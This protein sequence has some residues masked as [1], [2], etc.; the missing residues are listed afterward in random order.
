MQKFDHISLSSY[1][2]KKSFEKKKKNF[3]PQLPRLFLPVRSVEW[4]LI[5]R[6]IHFSSLRHARSITHTHER[7]SLSLAIVRNLE[8]ATRPRQEPQGR[9]AVVVG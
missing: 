1:K 4:S 2:R 8:G 7:L 5:F 6:V 9:F 3:A